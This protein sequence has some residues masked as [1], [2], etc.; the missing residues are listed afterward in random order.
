MKMDINY[1]KN[2]YCVDMHFHVYHCIQFE[3]QLVSNIV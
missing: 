1:A 3:H 2:I